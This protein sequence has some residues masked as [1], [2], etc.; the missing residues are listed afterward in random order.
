MNNQKIENIETEEVNE[1]LI[2]KNFG[3]IKNLKLD[4]KNSTLLI[5]PQGSGKSTIA[6]LIAIFRD[7]KVLFNNAD[8]LEFFNKYNIRN[9]FLKSSNEQ[10]LILGNTYLEYSC[11]HYK[12]TYNNEFTITR[13]RFFQSALDSEEKRIDK[14][15]NDISLKE[16]KRSNSD[17]GRRQMLLD[18]FNTNKELFSKLFLNLIQ[19]SVY[20]PA[21][22]SLTSIISESPFGFMNSGI[23]LPKFITDFGNLFEQ[24]RKS[25]TEFN[26]DFLNIRYKFEQ[27][28]NKVYFEK[29]N[30]IKLSESASGYQAIIPLLLV[31]E[32]LCKNLTY[33]YSFVVEEPELNLFPVSQKFLI[34][35]LVSKCSKNNNELVITTHSPYVL[36][37]FSNLLFAFQVAN[38][39]PEKE[40]KVEKI[41]SRNSW[42]DP[43]NFNAY[44]I[45]DGQA[46]PIFN[47]KTQLID[48]NQLDKVS[49]I[50]G[51]EYDALMQIYIEK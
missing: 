17:D 1:F 2:I 10:N 28:Q 42:L 44:Y 13:N 30:F 8:L 31:L 14:L 49:D 24:A 21:E 34:N 22:R 46:E 20:I 16:T 36:S 6:K 23:S 40:K 4:L 18:L 37:S 41:I 38:K 39:S 19:D 7:Y 9:Y 26:I 50:I 5:G 11:P 51:D 29:K 43:D 47:R 25:I 35:L 48:E 3:P 15:I 45:V 27:S 32:Y 33:K 12:I